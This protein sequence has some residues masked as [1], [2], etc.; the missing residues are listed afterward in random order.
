VNVVVPAHYQVLY[1]RL[2]P[3]DRAA[4]DRVVYRS[5]EFTEQWAHEA[6]IIPVSTWPLLRHRMNLDRFR[7][8]PFAIASARH[9]DYCAWVLDQIRER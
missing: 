7:R 3:Y 4:F 2:G 8:W 6:S 5:R 9:P 1:S